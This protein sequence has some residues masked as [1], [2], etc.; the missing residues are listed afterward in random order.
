MGGESDFNRTKPG[1]VVENT[2]KWKK[3]SVSERNAIE[4]DSMTGNWVN[5][6]KLD[7]LCDPRKGNE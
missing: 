6:G 1:N 4:L 2:G 5:R 3:N 7:R